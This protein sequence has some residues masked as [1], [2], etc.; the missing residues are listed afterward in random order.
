[1]PTGSIS[2]GR[3]RMAIW[4]R[5]GGR[6]ASS[7]PPRSP[8]GSRTMPRRW[9]LFTIRL[10]SAENGGDP[11]NGTVLSPADINLAHHVGLAQ[12]K[13]DH[14]QDAER[15]QRQSGLAAQLRDQGRARRLS[16]RMRATRKVKTPRRTAA[17]DHHQRAAGTGQRRQADRDH[18]AGRAGLGAGNESR[19]ADDADPAVD[20]NQRRRRP[21]SS[22]PSPT[23]Y[24]GA[25]AA[26]GTTNIGSTV[27]W[28]Y[29]W[30]NL[31]PGYFRFTAWV[32]DAANKTNTASRGVTLKLLQIVDMS[33]HQRPRPRRR[34][35]DR[36]RG[37]HADPAAER[38][39]RHRSALRAQSGV[40][41]QRR[42]P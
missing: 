27:Y 26:T 34:R 2:T 39:P 10:N 28:D 18:P 21:A 15:L 30:S 6:S 33:H 20:G 19:A 11:A 25:V 38:L 22:S 13:H 4:S 24:T 29:A 5:P 35:L 7:I 31:T 23:G 42:R 14:L 16:R 1:M 3:R 41:D 36:Q 12:R 40:L 17:V 8:S 9:T 32:R 37:K